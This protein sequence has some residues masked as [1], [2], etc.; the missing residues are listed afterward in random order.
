M[1]YDLPW[2]NAS[3][4]PFRLFKHWVHEGG[5]STPLIVRWPSGI[6]GHR[7]VHQP[8]HVVDIMS[9]ILEAAGL[10]QPSEYDG[11]MVRPTEG[12]S[13]L[14]G[15]RGE[16]WE[17]QS[18]IYW[19][20]EGNCAMRRGDWKLVRKYPGAWELYNLEQDRTELNNRIGGE[21]SRAREMI[22][23]WESWAERCGVVPWERLVD[24]APF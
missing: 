6:D 17:R 13:F 2:A 14:P 7:I 3:N 8:V 16:R 5:I 22:A 11:R 19:E 21:K 15:I 20:H 24:I 9:T 1:S 23:D 12:E 18:P 4:T 10:R